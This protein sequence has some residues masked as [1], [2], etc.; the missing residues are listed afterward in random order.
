M[1]IDTPNEKF[2]HKTVRE[3]GRTITTFGDIEINQGPVQKVVETIDGRRIPV[4]WEIRL[5]N[6]KNHRPSSES[7]DSSNEQSCGHLVLLHTPEQGL[8]SPKELIG[9]IVDQEIQG[10]PRPEGGGRR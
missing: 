9:E 3:N 10:Q 5:R 4:T 8:P 6:L 1:T 2:P 7:A